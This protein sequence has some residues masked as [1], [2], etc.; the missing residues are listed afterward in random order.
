M[1]TCISCFCMQYVCGSTVED[2][3]DTNINSSSKETEIDILDNDREDLENRPDWMTDFAFL[4]NFDF[5]GANE[6]SEKILF[7]ELDLVS[8][9]LKNIGYKGN[10]ALKEATIRWLHGRNECPPEFLKEIVREYWKKT[11]DLARIY[12][13]LYLAAGQVLLFS[14]V[15]YMDDERLEVLDKL[16]A[17]Q[18]E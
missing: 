14:L 5:M 17:A 16:G 2:E 1:V 12:T 10:E 7:K 4:D 18:Q 15:D 11:E 9:K 3:K 8:E 13:D 6:E